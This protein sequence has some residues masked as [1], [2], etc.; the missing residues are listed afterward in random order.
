MRIYLG[1]QGF[2]LV[3]LVFYLGFI[4]LIDIQV[5]ITQH[6]IEGDGDV[7]QF[8]FYVYYQR[9]YRNQASPFCIRS[10][11]RYIRLS[12]RELLFK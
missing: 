9:E 3:A 8:N 6:V 4:D 7:N 1:L 2:Q 12:C 5:E 11:V 10:M